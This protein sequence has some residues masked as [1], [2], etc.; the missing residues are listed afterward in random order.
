MTA[1]MYSCVVW[2]RKLSRYFEGGATG[3]FFQLELKPY[4]NR[5][6][7]LC[8]VTEF[9]LISNQKGFTLTEVMLVVVIIGILVAIGMPIYKQST[10]QANRKAVEA[11][12]RSIESAIMQYGS[13]NEGAIP[14]EE[15]LL[16]YF[17][18]WPIGPDGVEYGISGR[19]AIIS[20]AGKGDWFT[21]AEGDSLPI[22]W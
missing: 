7:G 5:E 3:R 1:Y 11:N 4:Y 19:K 8:R 15:D 20:K 10:A 2:A 17:Q 9:R 12:L 6:G 22:T 14:E 13:T 16:I 18:N 21:V